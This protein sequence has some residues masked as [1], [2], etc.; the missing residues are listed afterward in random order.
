MRCPMQHLSHRIG[1]P[2]HMSRQPI[3]DRRPANDNVAFPYNLL[4]LFDFLWMAG[5]ENGLQPSE[6]KRRPMPN[7]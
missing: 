6:S 1:S 5:T 3:P 4:E 7:M 2:Y